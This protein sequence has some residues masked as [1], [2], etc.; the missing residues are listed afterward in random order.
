MRTLL[1]VG[2]VMSRVRSGS[3]DHRPLLSAVHDNNVLF[4]EPVASSNSKTVLA[5]EDDEAWIKSLGL[6]LQLDNPTSGISAIAE[7]GNSKTV[8]SVA[9]TP[10][11][12]TI[13]AANVLT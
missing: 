2:S 6:S 10:A 9:Q 4:D 8:I 13:A 12:R 11:I 5:L 1:A 7:D 3:A